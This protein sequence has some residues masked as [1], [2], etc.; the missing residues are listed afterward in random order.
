MKMK[1]L[2]INA[3]KSLLL[4]LVVYLVFLILLPQAFSSPSS[5]AI[6]I[7]QA[8]IPSVIGW[9]LCFILNAKIWDF[10]VGAAMVLI[11]IIAA[12]IGI[13]FGVFAMVIVAI[14]LGLVFHT[15]TGLVYYFFQTPTIVTTIA[16]ALIYEAIGALYK[17]GSGFTIPSKMTYLGAPPFNLIIGF[18]CMI[19][20]YYIYNK[21]QFG[22]HVRAVGNGEKLAESMGIS[23]QKVRLIC[24]IV[25]GFFVGIASILQ[26][27]YGGSMVPMQNLGSMIIAFK[28]IMGVF[29]GMALLKFCN[30]IFGVFIGELTMSIITLGMVASGLP[31]T[32]QNIII[33]AFL[34]IFLVINNNRETFAEYRKRQRIL[35]EETVGNM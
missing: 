11:G 2:F 26:L 13:Q 18:I 5:M 16:M 29:I 34:I 3:V 23:P 22:Y 19:I 10:S 6:I 32:V 24:F 7:Q 17:G 25:C 31:A 33:G 14:I 9:G 21:T 1:T 12:D 30:L 27:S 28:P 35:Q 8:I 4:P 15:V 20:A